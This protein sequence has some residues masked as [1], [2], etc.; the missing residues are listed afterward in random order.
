MPAKI[1]APDL[2]SDLDLSQDELLGLLD[3]SKSVKSNPTRADRP[4]PRTAV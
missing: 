1:A 4:L 2:A 3:L